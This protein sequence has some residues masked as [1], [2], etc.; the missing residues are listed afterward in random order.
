M[1]SKT[2]RRQIRRSN[3]ESSFDQVSETPNVASNRKPNNQN[4]EQSKVTLSNVE[5]EAMIKNAVERELLKYGIDRNL[6]NSRIEVAQS[7][8]RANNPV[9][10]DVGPSNVYSNRA[11]HFIV[12]DGNNDRNRSRENNCPDPAALAKQTQPGPDPANCHMATEMGLP[13]NGNKEN[14]TTSAE[15]RMPNRRIP[16]FLSGNTLYDTTNDVLNSTMITQ[17]RPNRERVSSIT[18]LADA[19]TSRLPAPNSS[20][21]IKPVT[22]STLT[23]DG[24]NEKFEL[25]EDWFNT[26]IKMQPGIT[27]SMKI[28]QF[29]AHLRK[30]ALQTFHNIS[31]Q[32]KNRLEDILIVFRRKYVKPE[33]TATAKHKWHKFDF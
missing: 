18:R 8:S 2:R 26:L 14:K 5:V 6:N 33:S 28:N 10:D 17:E 32:N 9:I 15:T 12:S 30:G 23:F 11:T 13:R 3:Q 27:E 7:S 21:V 29:H 19:I 24:K 22:T 16:E 4:S 25:F 1:V 20:S 31:S